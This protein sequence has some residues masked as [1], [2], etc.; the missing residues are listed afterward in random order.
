V[1]ESIDGYARLAASVG[2]N[3]ATA[4]NG[5]GSNELVGLAMKFLPR[6]L[7]NVQD[8]DTV[9]AQQR[10]GLDAMRKHVLLLRRD[11]RDLMQSHAEA[12]EELRRMRQLQASM[13]AHLAR[14]QI[15]ELPGDGEDLPDDAP[16]EFAH[17]QQ[18]RRGAARRGP[19]ER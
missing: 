16:D 12:L 4:L 19:R 14:V 6:L 2:S 10:E 13:V 7:E 18:P 1:D 5:V 15:M 11:L 9:A 3:G 8:R 17:L